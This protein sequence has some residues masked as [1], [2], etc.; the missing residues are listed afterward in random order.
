M[1]PRNVVMKS[2]PLGRELLCRIIYDV[3]SEK[4]EENEPREER[5]GGRGFV[6]G[7]VGQK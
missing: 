7:E 6:E 2:L 3:S 4:R 1:D 5:G